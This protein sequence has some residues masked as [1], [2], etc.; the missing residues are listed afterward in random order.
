MLIHNQSHSTRHSI[1]V[2]TPPFIPYLGM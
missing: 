2:D 1:F